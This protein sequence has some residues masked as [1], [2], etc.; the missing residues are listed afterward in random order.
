MT[1]LLVAAV[2]LLALLG[3]PLFAA[4]AGGAMVGFRTTETPLI[5]TAIEIFRLAAQPTMITIPLF[6]F[7]GY[8][9]AEARTASRIVRVSRALL[10]WLPGGLAVVTLA[11]CAFFTTFTGA[12]G[13]T[14]IAIGG[15][16][17][18]VLEKEG[19]PERFNL[20]LITSSGSIGLLF[21]P[22]LPMIIYGIVYGLSQSPELAMAGAFEIDKFFLAGIAP[23]LVLVGTLSLFSVMTGIKHNVPRTAFAWGELGAALWEAKWE[24]PIPVFLLVMIFKGWITV[25]EAAAVTALYVLV[26]ECFIYR[27]LKLFGDVP[28]VAREAMILVGAIFVIICAAMCLTAFFIEADV[29]GRLYAL[30]DRYID[31]RW[32]FLL[33]LN[34]FLL[35]VGCLMDIFSAILVV[36]PLITVSAQHFG[37]DPYH[38]GIIFLVNL[39]IGYLTPP[40][41]MNL[42]I[43]SFRFQKPLVTLVRAVLPFMGLMILVLVVVTYIPWLTVGLLAIIAKIFLGKAAS[44]AP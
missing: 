42:F 16:L 35:I 36:V 34:I 17:Y 44:A 3:M 33:V 12:S 26:V 20:G 25:G 10:G 8:L 22:S 18:P 30:L 9:M 7:A 27:D 4:M 37:V 1:T 31:Q 14:I 32:S 24:V 2:V 28:R 38:L 21:P 15:L 39:E 29:P 23:G 43:A 11:A 41:G 5:S 13:V 40:F 6:T 19:Y